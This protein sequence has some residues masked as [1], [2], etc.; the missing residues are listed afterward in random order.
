MLAKLLPDSQGLGIA[1]TGE[2]A[3]LLSRA[4]MELCEEAARTVVL[5]VHREIRQG[6]NLTSTRITAS[7]EFAVDDDAR[8]DARSHR[9]TH[10][11]LESL[12]L[13]KHTHT[14]GE[15]VGIVVDARRNAKRLLENLL[16]IH[17]LP[18]RDIRHVIHDAL[19][20]INHRGHTHTNARHFWVHHLA[21]LIQ[22]LTS[23][24]GF[25]LLG[26]TGADDTLADHVAIHKRHAHVGSA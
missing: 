1:M 18:R 2:F 12:A 22:Q 4:A 11:V 8:A 17:L 6:A 16:Q 14:E 20:C 10:H 5:V 25:R 7:I 15:T 3:K 26:R 24:H 19:L 21:D 9:D 13:A 23:H